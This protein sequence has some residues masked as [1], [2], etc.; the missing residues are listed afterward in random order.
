MDGLA[1]A[2]HQRHA[3]LALRHQHGLAIGKLHRVLRRFRDALFAV[4]A[5]AGRFREFLAVGREQRRAA[6]DREIGALGIDDDAL[7]EFARGVDDVADH[8]RRQHALGIVGQQHDIGARQQRQD[9]VDQFLL[10][11]RRRPAAPTPSPRAA[12]GW[13]NARTR[14]APFASSAAPGSQTSTL[15][16]RLSRASS[17]FKVLPASSSPISPTK[18]QRAPSAGDIARDVAGAA[19]IGLAA[20]HGDHRRRRFRRNPRHLAIDEFV[21]HEVADAEHG[22]AG[23]RKRQGVKIEHRN[24]LSVAPFSGSDRRGRENP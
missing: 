17:A 6:I 14:S 21:Q 8:P 9:G 7:A 22:L 4:G 16:I 13:R 1:A 18:M 5:A 3:V 23:H 2:R 12:C 24:S 20:L 11:R 10:D 15:S 19:D